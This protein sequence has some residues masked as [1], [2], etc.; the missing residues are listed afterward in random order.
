[1]DDKS[2]I[3][4]IKKDPASFVVLYDAYYHSIFSYI[5]R[6][7]GDY[8]KAR[9]ISSE[10]FLKAYKGVPQFKWRG[11]PLSAWLYRIASNEIN[12]LLRHQ[13][14]AEQWKM[15]MQ[16]LPH[17][18]SVESEKERIEKEAARNKEFTR[19]QQELLQLDPDHQEVIALRFFEEKS[20]REISEITGKKDG[21]VKSL[22][23]RGLHKLRSKLNTTII[24]Q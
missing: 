5:F 6:R 18:T 24:Q 12:M 10:T 9:D 7:L 22:L 14:Y 4:Q 17:D 16:K 15:A 13:R 23:S 19:V 21:T 1:M 8:E 11:I 3:E 20:I 2:L